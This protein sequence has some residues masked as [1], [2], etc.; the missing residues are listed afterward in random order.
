MY[1]G[2]IFFCEAEKLEECIRHKKYACTGNEAIRP[3]ELPDGSTIFLY[4]KDR[5]ILLGPFTANQS[6][7]TLEKGAWAEDIDEH[8]ASANVKVEWEELHIL[9]KAIELLPFLKDSKNC[10]LS[11]SQ[12]QRALDMLKEAPLYNPNELA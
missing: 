7:L 2:Y 5:E 11:E 4:N 1:T 6:G 10:R 3:K 9:T 8:S 12:T